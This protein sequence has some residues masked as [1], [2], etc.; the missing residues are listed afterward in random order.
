MEIKK[1]QRVSKDAL[2]DWNAVDR[3]STDCRSYK[4]SPF[5]DPDTEEVPT[6]LTVTCVA[7]P[8]S[9]EDIP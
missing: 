8:A 5:P 3:V 4:K 6:R 1:R 9:N 7:A 2:F